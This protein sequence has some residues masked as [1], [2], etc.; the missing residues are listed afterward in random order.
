MVD[1]TDT[2]LDV[3]DLVFID[4][5]ETGFTRAAPGVAPKSFYNADTDA[6]SAADFVVAW[7]KANGREASPK[8]VL[9]ESYGTIRAALMAGKLAKAAPLDGVFLFGQAVNMIETSQRTRNAVSYAANLPQLATIAAYHGRVDLGGKL[10]SAFIDETYAW[11][12]S[13]YLL[14]LV[15]GQDLGE[16]ERRKIAERLQALTGIGADYYLAHRLVIS[17]VAFGRELLRD[18]GL[19]LGTYDARY[20]G[21]GPA[22]GARA[23]DPFAPTTA[24]IQPMMAEHLSKTLGVTWPTADYRDVAPGS[25]DWSWSPTSG[26]GGPFLD[27]DYSAEISKAFKAN[28]RFRLMVGTGVYDLTTTVGPARYLVSSSDFPRDQVFMRQYVGGHMAYTHLPSLKAF[29]GDIRAFVT[30]GRP[31]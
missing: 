26:A 10:V 2:V 27:Y 29:T 17:K 3:A 7:C 31:V 24:A 23:Q 22:P 6:Q 19:I 1:N 20:T 14:A 9:G 11:A 13:D 21:P 12:M 4:P 28:P 30:G 16:V 15:K 5:A 8:Y 18:K 25:D